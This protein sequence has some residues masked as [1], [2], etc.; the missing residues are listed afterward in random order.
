MK[1]FLADPRS[2]NYKMWFI[3]DTAFDLGSLAW[4][5]SIP[6]ISYSLTQS[7]TLAGL[8]GS[9]VAFVRL[10]MLLPSGV[11]ADRK[12]RIRTVFVFGFVDALL[13]IAVGILFL[14]NKVSFGFF[15]FFCIVS[16]AI[17]TIIRSSNNALLKDTVPAED[18]PTAVSLNEGRNSAIGM[19]GGPIG[20]FLFSIL[21]AL[22]VFLYSLTSMIR[23]ISVSLI[24]GKP[25]KPEKKQKVKLSDI[26]WGA[27]AVLGI[28][29]LRSLT[30]LAALLNFAGTGIFVV[31]ILNLQLVK[32]DPLLI[33]MVFTAMG[34]SGLL[35]AMAASRVVSKFPSGIVIISGF[36]WQ[37]VWM[38]AI[39]FSS[40]FIW[41]LTCFFLA[42]LSSPSV[43]AASQGFLL[44][45]VPSEFQGRVGSSVGFISLSVAILSPLLSGLV[46][47][48]WGF[49]K[50]VMLFSSVY[51][52]VLIYSFFSKE[53]RQIPKPEKWEDHA[54]PVRNYFRDRQNIK[55]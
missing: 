32:T 30:L 36:T 42:M 41:I 46:L 48:T 29:T 26:V 15:V 52:V 22:P 33:G 13:G 51:L 10:V 5:T 6:L 44:A 45:A 18:F 7:A 37:L 14:L 50:A 24:D 49:Q 43:S 2:R 1:G 21:N 3:G 40:N 16:T 4:E 55:A 27:R 12:N 47:E 39:N 38:I 53:L 54:V 23:A 11:Y 17:A 20:G 34:V 9:L 19:I 25:K 8:V 35:G 31:V 28:S